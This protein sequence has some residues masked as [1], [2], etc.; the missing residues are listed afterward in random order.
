MNQDEIQKAIG[1]YYPALVLDSV[2]S[3]E[4]RDTANT[5]LEGVSVILFILALLGSASRR[6][7]GSL[8][9]DFLSW[10]IYLQ[11]WQPNILGLLMVTV[12]L[13]ILAEMFKAFYNSHYFIGL[14]TMLPETGLSDIKPLIAFE[15]CSVLYEAFRG[16]D[17][18]RGFVNSNLGRR[19][20][21]RAGAG[22]RI[23]KDFFS[24]RVGNAPM[25]LL[26]L[27]KKNPED[28]EPIGMYEVTSALMS[29]DQEFARALSVQ[30]ISPKDLS[31][32]A[33]WME[34]MEIYFRRRD[35]F[36]SKDSLGRIRGIG[37]NWA[38][39]GAHTLEKFA[40]DITDQSISPDAVRSHA[41]EQAELEAILARSGENNALLVADEGAGALD[42]VFGLAYRISQGSVLPSLEHKRVYFF[43]TNAFIANVKDKAIFE[44][45]FLHILNESVHAG[46][47]ILV[48]KDLPNFIE[49]AKSLGADVVALL[50]PYL[51][52]P[53]F[54][55]IAVTNPG[56]F[57][58]GLEGDG[59]ILHRFE[60]IQVKE[61][62]LADTLKMLEDQALFE[63]SNGKVFFTYQSL[64][65]V[66]EGAKRYFGEGVL[67]DKALHLL[68]EL[69][70][71]VQAKGKNYV[72]RADV[73]ALIETKTG[74]KTG[75]VAEG[76]RETLL[77]LEEVLHKRIVGQDEAIKAIANSMRR[78]RSDI[79][80]PEKP[81]GSFLFLGPTGV[82]KTE[83][84]KALA[85]TFFGKEESIIRL[86]MSEYQTDD[87]LKR[88]I[89]SFENGKQGVLSSKLREQSYGV[90][91]LDEFE[92]TNKEVLNLFLQILDEGFFS[93]MSGKRVN[94]RN[95]II[96]ATSNAGSDLIWKMLSGANA[97]GTL[98]KDVII[99]E[100]INRG[101]FRPELLN[102]FDGVILFHPLTT[103]NL[104]Q[105]AGLMLKKLQK[106]LT[107]KGIELVI[108]DALMTAVM[109]AGTDPQFGARPMNRAIQEKV[110]QVIA[111]KIIAGVAKSGSR[112]ELTAEELK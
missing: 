79:T 98:N 48:I 63:E 35:R 39:G 88:L 12:S 57:H 7:A 90:L 46:N 86:D 107:E 9:P 21:N 50:D 37:K 5:A 68:N 8:P 24:S 55:V 101:I 16:N 112:I 91:L 19:A 106:R 102:R 51:A 84:T 1:V 56:A 80:N 6:F 10:A 108:N 110:E 109:S 15:A 59:K 77:K 23:L 96:I 11:N 61:S 71:A 31:G 65:A 53:D 40:H 33:Q 17:L 26:T 70:P 34:R 42:A 74:I 89:G 28:T 43:D 78:S 81:M 58:Q 95:L 67:S 104:Q 2:I 64:S 72:E 83:T 3:R 99:N 85:S 82:G 41:G 38:Y 111:H 76:E 93:D 29:L 52:S 13:W 103:E 94:A 14:S 36:W 4:T 25:T 49:S 100:I 62:D 105:I 69:V 75:A 30:D 60:K 73:L 47:I 45:T 92:K 20:L 54:Q 18:T 44:S 22:P 66:A 97:E 32:S 27:P 87:S